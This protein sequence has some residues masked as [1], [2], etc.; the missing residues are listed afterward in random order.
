MKKT[1]L[2]IFTFKYPFEPPTE[3]FLDDELRFLAEEDAD[4]LLVPSARE[5]KNVLYT[6]SGTR[7]NISV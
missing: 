2:I 4:I 3:Q 1:L 6:F 5:K 7:D